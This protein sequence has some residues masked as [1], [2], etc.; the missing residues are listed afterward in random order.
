MSPRY[1]HIH[2]H[3]DSHSLS[4]THTHTRTASIVSGPGG[5][6]FLLS[7]R[8]AAPLR[9]HTNPLTWG[10]SS[11]RTGRSPRSQTGSS[12]PGR[13]R[14]ALRQHRTRPLGPGPVG[15]RSPGPLL[16]LLPSSSLRGGRSVEMPPADLQSGRLTAGRG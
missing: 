10:R 16:C 15:K 6:S 4:L 12:A 11:E 2:S 14:Q 3:A 1:I 8:S 7:P 5:T 9:P 13:G